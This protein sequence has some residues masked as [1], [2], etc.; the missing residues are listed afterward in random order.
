MTE[1]T[2]IIEQEMTIQTNRDD[3]HHFWDND[4]CGKKR[5]SQ[6]KHVELKITAEMMVL[7]NP[8]REV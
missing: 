7:V 5:R 1:G 3:V 2:N 4:I 8:D 6:Q